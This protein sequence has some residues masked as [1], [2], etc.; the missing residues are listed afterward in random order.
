MRPDGVVAADARVGRAA[1]VERRGELVR[2][3]ARRRIHDGMR[4]VDD[5]E[6]LVSPG[7]ALGTFV[8]AVAHPDRILRQ[9]LGGVGGVEDELRHLPVALVRVVEVVER[10]EEPVLQGELAGVRRVGCDMRVDRRLRGLGQSSRPKLVVAAGIERVAREVEVILVAILEVRRV[11][12]D[13]DEVGAVPRPAKRDGRLL[14]EHV[15]VGRNV[16]LARPALDRL[17]DEADDRRVLLRERLLVLDPCERRRG[18]RDRD[19]ARGEPD[20]QAPDPPVRTGARRAI[21]GHASAVFACCRARRFRPGSEGLRRPH[22]RP[23]CLR[24]EPPARGRR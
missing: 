8:R 17:I 6:L 9:R 13:L 24:D 1:E 10:V 3:G 11:G 18:E 23:G 5:L 12:P 7:R 4:S 2:V 15:H 22:R 20:Q 21:A 16:G 14:E 19:H